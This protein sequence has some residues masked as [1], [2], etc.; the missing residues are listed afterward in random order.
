MDAAGPIP[1]ELWN[2]TALTNLY[3]LETCQNSA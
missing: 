3:D 2:L 1:E